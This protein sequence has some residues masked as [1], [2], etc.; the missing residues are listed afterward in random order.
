VPASSSP[1][2]VLDGSLSLVIPVHNEAANVDR[3]LGGCLNTLPALASQWD[4]ILVDDGSTDDT[5]A[6]ARRSMGRE[7]SRL[8]LI[9]H[10][11]RLGYGVTVAD[12]LRAAST[13]YVAFMDGDGQFDPGDL[14]SL[15]ALMPTADLAAGWRRHR[16]D[17]G[18]RIVIAGVFNALVRMVYG[19]HVRDLDCGLK[20]MRR[21]TLDSASPLLARSA[22]LNTELYFKAQRSGLRIRQVPVEHYPRLAGV[23]SGARLIPILRAIRDLL[24][25]RLRLAQQ[26][27]APSKVP[28][29][30]ES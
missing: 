13:D 4:I 26:W 20:L 10:R 23:R 29:V 8:R 27:R 21:E 24:W 3:V 14:R 11:A 16:A 28:S 15:A 7:A 19:I 9:Q 17:P 30:A 22:L 18:Y 25:L 5:V 1:Q 2:S 12:G 6:Q